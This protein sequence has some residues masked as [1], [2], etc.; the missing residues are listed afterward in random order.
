MWDGVAAMDAVFKGQKLGKVIKSCF[1]DWILLWNELD[2]PVQSR[3]V[4]SVQQYRAMQRLND[5]EARVHP[6]FGA[7]IE[8]LKNV[9]QFATQ[10]LL[11][12]FVEWA[13]QNK[14]PIRSNA[15]ACLLCLLDEFCTT[16][17]FQS[18]VDPA[19]HVRDIVEAHECDEE[20]PPG[21]LCSHLRKAGKGSSSLNKGVKHNPEL[22]E[23]LVGLRGSCLECDRCTALLKHILG[24][25]QAFI[26]SGLE[27]MDDHDPSKHCPA[28]G[29]RRVDDDLREHLM[30]VMVKEGKAPSSA[31]AVRSEFGTTGTKK[32]RYWLLVQTVGAAHI[33]FFVVVLFEFW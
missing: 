14:G 18:Q 27:E 2:V 1:T 25:M 12:L 17:D 5:A 32:A 21:D 29:K 30:N 19:T 8:L 13:A 6:A 15:K 26:H 20:V 11:G 31:A 3:F 9:H 10:A 4:P 28:K 33:M 16:V 7:K 23:L 24:V 22:V